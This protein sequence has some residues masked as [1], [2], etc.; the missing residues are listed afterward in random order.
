[1][2]S[3]PHWLD[4]AYGWYS[5]RTPLFRGGLGAESTF[6]WLR[7]RGLSFA[8]PAAPDITWSAEREEGGARVRDGEFDS[9]FERSLLPAE[10]RRA[11]LRWLLPRQGDAQK[12][13]VHLAA[14]GDEGYRRRTY[15]AAPLLAE[16]VGALILENPFYGAR[17][18]VGQERGAVRTVAEQLVMNL[19]SIDEALALAAWARQEGLVAGF[20]GY[21]QGGHMAALATAAFPGPIAAALVATGDSPLPIFTQ[22]L[23][24][25]TIAWES[26]GERGAA[27]AVFNEAFGRASATGLPP[28][29]APRAAVVLAALRDGYVARP[30][31]EALLAH[32]KGAELR[33]VGGGHVSLLLR[34]AAIA[35]AMRDA[36]AR[37]LDYDSRMPLGM[38]TTPSD[39]TKNLRR[40]ASAS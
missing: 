24:S 9:P 17:R 32:W 3:T 40:S 39:D 34:R 29:R 5:R 28:P 6:A 8:R 10:S 36:L 25:R 19:A 21:S 35:A 37:L 16:G 18:P 4:R 14:T 27:L 38:T 12:V 7:E 33:W 15:L 1:M 13:Y 20:T 31:V 23:L 26:L 22:G 30:S 11:R 2:G